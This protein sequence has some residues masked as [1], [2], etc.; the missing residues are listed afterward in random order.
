VIVQVLYRH[1]L[2]KPTGRAV[3]AIAH[4]PDA[5]R[6]V[7]TSH[8][9]LCAYRQVSGLA[10]PSAIVELEAEAV[11][12]DP[13]GADQPKAGTGKGKAEPATPSA[14]QIFPENVA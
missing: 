14:R 13:A 5:Q 3:R 4:T 9:W 1:D 12:E 6:L 10:A 8:S 2:I 11:K 7:I